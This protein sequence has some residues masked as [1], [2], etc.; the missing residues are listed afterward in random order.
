M[1]ALRQL[2]RFAAY[3]SL[4]ALTVAAGCSR[5]APV[6]SAPESRSDPQS[7]LDGR[8]QDHVDQNSPANPGQQAPGDAASLTNGDG[9]GAPVD[10][11]SLPTG[12]L[13]TVRLDKPISAGSPDATGTFEAIVDEPVVVNG[14][15]LVPAGAHAAG[16]VESARTSTVKRDR[17]YVRLTLTTLEID[18]RDLGLQTSSL[19]TQISTPPTLS[20]VRSGTIRL[21]KGRRLTFRLTRPAN[22]A[23]EQPVS[24]R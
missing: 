12:T 11:H 22:L 14:T 23:S 15:T 10:S 19:F 9:V 1:S 21:D 20:P 2:G 13:L 4:L 16:L 18:G 17:G 24:T 6:Q 7:S 3:S 5:P 8:D